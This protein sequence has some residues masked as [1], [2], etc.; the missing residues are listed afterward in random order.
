MARTEAAMAILIRVL[1]STMTR[2]DRCML[3]KHNNNSS[4][5]SSRLMDMVMVMDILSSKHNSKAMVTAMGILNS[6]H[7][8][9]SSRVTEGMAIHR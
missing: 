7:N 5:N 8:S 2:S 1:R 4:S 6:K 3:S 9:S